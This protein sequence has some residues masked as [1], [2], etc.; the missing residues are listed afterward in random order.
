MMIN[1]S[2]TQL[3]TCLFASEYN[4]MIESSYVSLSLSSEIKHRESEKTRHN[5][6]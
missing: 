1:K 2:E 4:E 6:M 5:I 3:D